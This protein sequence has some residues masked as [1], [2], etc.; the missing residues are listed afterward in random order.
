[1]HGLAMPPYLILKRQQ[2]PVPGESWE[3]PPK[4]A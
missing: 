4:P 1:M 3:P 2:P